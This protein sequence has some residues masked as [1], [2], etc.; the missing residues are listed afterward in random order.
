MRIAPGLVVAFA[1]CLVP[2]RGQ[3]GEI[4][5]IGDPAPAMAVS[6]WVKGKKVE[7]FEPGK[8]YVV[9]FWATWCVPCRASIPHL[10]ELARRYTGVRF[11]GVDVLEQDVARVKPFV[12][13]MGEKMAYA[14]ALDA[15]PASGDPSDGAMAKGWLEAAEEKGIPVA[16]V[17]HDCAIAWIGHP[18]ELDEPLA[19]IVAG[20]WRPGNL[21][22]NRLAGRIRARKARVVWEKGDAARKALYP[23]YDAGDYPGVLAAFDKATGGDPDLVE[24]FAWLKF[25]SLC[26]GG[27]VEAGLELGETLYEADKDDPAALV[28]FS[29]VLGGSYR[30]EPDPR[31]ARLALRALRR[32]VVISEGKAQDP[33]LILNLA[34]A[35][36]RTGDLEAA[37]AT[38]ERARERLERRF[39]DFNLPVEERLVRLYDNDLAGLRLAACYD[40]D[41]EEALAMAARLLEPREGDDPTALLDRFG[42]VIRPRGGKEPDRRIARLAVDALQ[43]AV[44][45][46]DGDRPF[47]LDALAEA[48]YRAGDA[49]GAAATEEKAIQRLEGDPSR[50]S[51]PSLRLLEGRLERYRKAAAS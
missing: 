23:L 30:Q 17:I 18:M 24:G 40:R 9:E 20:D 42:R 44:A 3:A 16:F 4:L 43:R 14:V 37:V 35:E 2:P 6:G 10:T 7:R 32:A 15:V 21:A 8:T 28:R 22:A 41:A 19:K 25:A 50:R 1:A 13:E 38:A 47:Y 26:N 12:D 36:Y 46:P 33:G 29:R 27:D 11:V 34:E 31:A 5:N 45:M 49:A 48:Q 39:K 51:A